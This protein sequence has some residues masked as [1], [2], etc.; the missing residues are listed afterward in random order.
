MEEGAPEADPEPNPAAADV[1]PDAAA[2]RAEAIAAERARMKAV[3]ASEHVAG[4]E[5]AAV[6]LL[7]E[8]DMTA[9]KI[10]AM[11]P[12]L[13]ASSGVLTNL[14]TIASTPNPDLGAGGET[15]GV[16]ADNHGWSKAHASVNRMRSRHAPR[17]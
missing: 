8:S 17:P 9:D 11:L 6:E 15:E 14:A 12:K 1:A 4:R 16:K 5:A 13:G 2:I 3:F 10:V 7:A